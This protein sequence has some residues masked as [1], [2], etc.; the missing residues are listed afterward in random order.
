MSEPNTN[1]SEEV[2]AS[3]TVEALQAELYQVQRRK[4]ALEQQE[5]RLMRLLGQASA[6][7]L[8]GLLAQ[9]GTNN[10][11]LQG[12]VRSTIGVSARKSG[13]PAAPSA[14]T[15][16]ARK[17][18]IQFRHPDE[19]GLVWSGRGKTPRWVSALQAQG[20]LE[21]ARLPSGSTE[22]PAASQ[23]TAS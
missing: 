9:A 3:A 8:S 10:A 14:P 11:D 16:A 13:T 7:R 2:D 12:L 6:R 18:P 23:R 22:P 21:Q 1:A 15:T 19:P 20:R 17:A 5:R 4:Q